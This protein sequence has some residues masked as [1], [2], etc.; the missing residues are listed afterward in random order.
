MACI[1]ELIPSS[2]WRHVNGL[3]NPADCASRGIFPS[4]LVN[5][6]LWWNGPEWLKQT[7]EH[8]P[9]LNMEIVRTS[10][11]D[12]SEICLSVIVKTIHPVMEVNRFS[13]FTKLKR[14]TA[15]ILRFVNNC[16]KTK[17]RQ[18]SPLIPAELQAAEQ[19][20]LSVS[21]SDHFLEEMG[22]LRKTKTIARSS[23]LLHLHPFL[24]E[25]SLLRVGGRQQT[26]KSSQHPIIIH[27]N[28][29]ITKLLI[30]SEHLRLLH[31]GPQLLTS[32][33]SQRFHI[34]GHR[35]TIRSITRS[36]IICRKNS[37]KPKPQ[38]LFQWNGSLLTLYLRK[39]E[40]IMQVPCT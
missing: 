29:P 28:H 40:S 31:A 6:A 9:Q 11:A 23:S 33:L 27:G 24:D 19:F 30:I 15:W 39:L 21:Q 20:W 16:R 8:W 35:K 37:A 32:M 4:E 7:S 17:N 18:T 14:V 1:M 10:A 25:S 13:S 22:T 2:H 3:E 5:H 26:T 38:L 12:D 34:I 36:C